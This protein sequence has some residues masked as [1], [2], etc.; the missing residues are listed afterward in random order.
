MVTESDMTEQ[1]RMHEETL[2]NCELPSAI[3]KPAGTFQATCSCSQHTAAQLPS[4][5][6]WFLKFHFVGDGIQCTK[7]G[8]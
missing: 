8:S 5:E 3:R 7:S 4:H 2:W 1:L 6:T